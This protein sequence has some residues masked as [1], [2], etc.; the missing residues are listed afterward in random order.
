MRPYVDVGSAPTLED[1]AQVGSPDYAERGNR[2]CRAHL[3][4]PRRIFGEEP[5][6]AHFGI[7]ANP[8][9]FGTY[10]SVVCYYDDR[11]PDS[12]D[13]AFRCESELPEHWDNQ[14]RQELAGERK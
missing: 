6:G 5:D 1:C 4:Q 2:K 14:A 12:V 9:D 10:Y 3:R 13:Y 7:K 8:H 11:H